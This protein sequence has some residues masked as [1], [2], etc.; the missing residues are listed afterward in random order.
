MDEAAVI[1]IAAEAREFSGILRHASRVEPAG[2]P[3]QFARRVEFRG[4]RWLLAAN[5]PGPRLAAVAASEA[6]D[7]SLACAVVSTGVC[8]GLDP[9]LRI[10]D[11][12]V[13]TGIWGVDRIA[14]KRPGGGRKSVE[15][16]VLSQDR[17]V[18]AVQ[19]KKELWRQGA[20]AAEMEAEAVAREA[21]RRGV[22]FYCVRA[23]SDR[24]DQ[25]LPLD[26]NELRDAEG[27]FSTPKI[28]KCAIANPGSIPGLIRL[29]R[30]ARI[31][32]LALGEY[33]AECEF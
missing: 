21:L 27:R 20:V 22:T 6:L 17:V 33:F 32:S 9:A 23:V 28:L 11:I 18:I 3:V 25:D 10:G 2:L 7:S 15:G 4:R 29:A 1:A 12:V 31:A 26:F 5:G 30:Q 24:A 8:G 19:Q 16:A 14:V 13:A